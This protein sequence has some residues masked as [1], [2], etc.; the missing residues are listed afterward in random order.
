MSKSIQWLCIMFMLILPSIV[1]AQEW[2]ARYNGP[3]NGWDGGNALAVDSVGNVYVTGSS[4]GV[5]GLYDYATIKY[6]S[7][8]VEQ[9]I[10][11]YNGPGNGCDEPCTIVV[12]DSGN[13]Y[14][15]GRSVGA[16]T[17]SDY[18]TI[19]YNSS[20]VE[21]WIARYNGPGNIGDGAGAIVVDDSGN[22]YVTGYSVGAGTGSD[23]ATIKYNS[24]G[25][26]Q[27]V[28]RYNS[29]DS[30]HDT[31]NGI[32]IDNSGNIFVGGTSL[33]SKTADDYVVVK[34]NTLGV[35]QWVTQYNGT[36][37]YRDGARALVISSESNVYVTGYSIGLGSDEDYATVKYNSSGIEQWTAR[38]N[39]PGNDVDYAC[40]IAVDSSGNV[41]VAG[42][43]EGSGTE[44][45][46][47]VV[48]YD[49]LG[50]EQW[51]ARYNGPGNSYDEA[52]EMV[53]DNAGNSYVT[54]YS[55]DLYTHADYATV[56]YNAS[57]VEQWVVRYNGPIDRC[58][59]ASAIA[60]DNA[61]Y[62]YVTGWSR[63]L[64]IGFDFATIKYSPV[65][66]EESRISQIESSKLHATIFSGVLQLPEGK[67]CKVYDITGRV[68]EPGKILPGI[69]F[70]EIDGEVVQKVVKIR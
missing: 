35:E 39:G 66:I 40:A 63:G 19:K 65:G 24:S 1:P 16:G 54:G 29:P 12:D 7:T 51:V 14:V 32:A 26:E 31:A 33:R 44:F 61:G 10:A 17:G 48:K 27:W 20:G 18:T 15:T 41:Y 58:D 47:A 53:I 28:A 2:V 37:N 8:G 13:V 56:K 6:S 67:K 5:N 62:I 43:S 42:F 64:D 70:L 25:V 11:R 21:Q 59:D 52:R 60:V 45:D 46:Y 57:G 3:G 34:Y 55:I 49:S 50:V 38:Y 23:Y 22:V 36:G 4:D 69:Y 68:V 9:W 30:S